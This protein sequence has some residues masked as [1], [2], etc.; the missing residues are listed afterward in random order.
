MPKRGMSL[1]EAWT[2]LEGATEPRFVPFP[3]I[4]ISLGTS[5]ASTER[6]GD[7]QAPQV[8]ILL[9]NAAFLDCKVLVAEAWVSTSRHV[10]KAPQLWIWDL[11]RSQPCVAS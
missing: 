10:L 1:E 4:F 3:T 11:N 9:Y 5:G 6:M 7:P 8:F 2:S